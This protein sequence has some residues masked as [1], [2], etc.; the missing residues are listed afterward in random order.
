MK[1]FFIVYIFLVSSLIANDDIDSKIHKVSSKLNTFAKTYSNIS[2]KMSRNAKAIL[3]QKR[4]LAEQNQLLT[5]LQRILKLKEKH[6]LKNNKQ[7]HSLDKS[8]KKLQKIQDKLEEDLVFVIAQNITLSIILDQNRT[9]DA[10]SLIEYEV[11]NAMLDKSKRKIKHLNEKFFN[12]SQEMHSLSKNVDKLK[13]TIADIDAKKMKILKLKNEN[14]LALARLEKDKEAY[15]KALTKLLKK[16]DSIKKT[17]AGLNIIKIDKIKKEKERREREAA[18]ERERL[19]NNKSLPK[20]KQLGSSYQAIKTKRYYGE[21]TIAPLDN[22]TITKKYGTYTDPIYGIK[23]F[24]E[25][26]SLKPRY[27]H[28]KVKTVFNGKVIY[29]DKTAVLNNIVII[30]HKNGLH[31]IYANLA[32]IAPNIKKGTKIRKGYTIGRVDDELIF[33]VT[34]KSQHINPIRLFQ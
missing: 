21:K 15:K 27:K 12:N 28:S 11:L 19:S 33:E 17:L 25:S 9:T 8:Q 14:K 1:V 23:I 10:E 24:N 3:E 22:Y 29:A 31:T 18:F 34:Q 5:R 4:K 6:Y 32:K 2:A 13:K 30:E 16:Q 20:I 26:I 7:L